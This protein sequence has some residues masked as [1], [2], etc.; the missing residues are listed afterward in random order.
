M[1]MRNVV[2]SVLL[3]ISLIHCTEDK[4][5]S[6]SVN[7]GRVNVSN[8]RQLVSS[9]PSCPSYEEVVNQ[10]VARSIMIPEV[11]RN[12][13]EGSHNPHE[14]CFNY[15]KKVYEQAVKRNRFLL[16]KASDAD[17][18]EQS[19][20][21]LVKEIQKIQYKHGY[22][23]LD[24]EDPV[25]KALSIS[26]ALYNA[27]GYPLPQVTFVQSVRSNQL[28]LIDLHLNRLYGLKEIYKE[29]CSTIDSLSLNRNKLTTVEP[30][31]LNGFTNIKKIS[32]YK[33]ELRFLP[34][35]LF[36]DVVPTMEDL[37]LQE[38]N[39]SDEEKARIQDELEAFGIE[40]VYI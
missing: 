11:F 33:N 39:F 5:P 28:N 22:K 36:N 9:E 19:R 26:P 40:K 12:L 23:K 15:F 25:S 24:P 6:Y 4:P 29:Q 38:N 8:G 10:D 2:V 21:D 7:S 34:S 30:G 14:F 32:F 31:F 16:D 20:K 18:R 3:S 27:I 13:A 17:I 37:F 1:Q 35:G